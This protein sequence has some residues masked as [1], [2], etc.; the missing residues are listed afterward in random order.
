M[1]HDRPADRVFGLPCGVDLAAGLVEGFYD[2][3]GHLAPQDVARSLIIVNTDRLRQ[4]MRAAF[5][6]RGAALLPRMMLITD[7]AA[8]SRLLQDQPVQSSVSRQLDLAQLITRLIEA[9]PDLAPRASVFDLAASLSDLFGEMAGEGVSV[10]DVLGLDV[11]DQSGHWARALEFMSIAHRFVGVDAAVPHPDQLQRDGV[12]DLIQRWA[13]TPPETPVIIA[14]STGSRG[15][16]LR[17]MG[18]I[19]RLPHGA[20][21][22][23]GFDFDQPADVWDRMTG[24]TAQQDHPQYRAANLVKM[25]DGSAVAVRR[26][27]KAPPPC[28]PR[29]A[30][31]SLALRP[32]PV[33]DQWLTDGARFTQVAEATQA[34][35]LVEARGPRHEAM[36]IALRMRAAVAEGRTCALITPDR[37]LT[38]QVAAALDRWDIRPDD[39][40][41]LPLQQ[42]PQG[43]LMRQ[44]LKAMSASMTS[45]QLIA[46][47]KHP[48]VAR[49][50]DQRGQHL[51]WT[52]ELELYLRKM[53]V[54]CPEGTA[55]R[56]WLDTR[57][58]A[59]MAE[60][61]VQWIETVFAPEEA[62]SHAQ[63]HLDRCLSIVERLVGG[64]AD[65][66]TAPF[67]S[68]AAG[69]EIGRMLQ[70]LGTAD[71]ASVQITATEFAQFLSGQLSARQVRSTEDGHPQVSIFGP[72]EAR[73]QSADVVILAGLNEGV[74]PG[75]IAPDPWLNRKMRKDAGLLL[76]ERQVGLSA[77]DFQQGIAAPEVWL[78]RAARSDDAE[79]VPSRWLNRLLNL[80]DGLPDGSGKT[81]LADMRNRAQ[82]WLSYATQ[83]EAVTPTAPQPRPAPRPPVSARPTRLSVTQ[84]KT[85]IRDPYAI[86]A[87]KVL[88][89]RKLASLDPQPS[90]LLRGIALHKVVED[91]V[92]TTRDDDP[93]PHEF[94]D[95]ADTV[96]QDMVPW[97]TARLAWLARCRRLA[98]PFVQ[99]EHDRRMLARPIAWEV[100][101]RVPV[102]DFGFHLTGTAD[103]VDLTGD[104]RAILY[105]YK[106]GAI[107]TAAQQ[108]LFDKQLFLEIE[109]L[110]RGGFHNLPDLPVAQAAYLG[111]GS[112][113]QSVPVDVDTAAE[114][115]QQFES[116]ITRYHSADQ[117]YTARRAVAQTDHAS[118][119]DHL[120]RYGEWDETDAPCPVD[121]S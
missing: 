53:M 35:T 113:P 6:A 20:V 64:A 68:G 45:A 13:E 37:V 46:I 87:S 1:T 29:N 34:L 24:E 112:A 7:L 76:P 71:L 38:R 120:S 72:Q 19:A 2:Q 61:W 110:R 51:I 4:K 105:D 57:L 98:L 47:L 103:R 65:Q 3:F 26:W 15:A 121:L 40:A 92:Q 91:F 90:P 118:D 39:S 81:A 48:L 75:N 74:W 115:W 119:F 89:L 116:L 28:P 25:L 12:E 8:T 49:D 36:L 59:E 66:G 73:M 62:P 85:L 100:T 102:G 54:P 18:A 106:T 84:I 101:G 78:C 108:R 11:S 22:L 114:V 97:P 33:T 52:R 55:L 70:E 88:N 95:I 31:V 32:A 79:T 16:T 83:L 17:L 23:P 67:W 10:D 14:G 43:R 86:Y 69:Q 50:G 111:L 44:V 30:L 117:P 104:G 21:V 96:L 94:C 60:T 77:H 82:P 41:G 99:D 42:T 58:D 63:D 109:M 9:Q 93:T 80:L 27:H 56:A 107:P 5:Q